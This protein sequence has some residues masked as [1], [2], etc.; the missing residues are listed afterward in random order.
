MG[1]RCARSAPGAGR[2]GETQTAGAG[3]FVRLAEATGSAPKFTLHPC[4]LAS[5]TSPM[6]GFELGAP[7][8]VQISRFFR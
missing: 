5:G 8:H 7:P 3:P 6:C 4:A 2:G 1:R